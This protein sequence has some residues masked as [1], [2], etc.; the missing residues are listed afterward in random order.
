M[1]PEHSEHC[2]SCK[3][4]VRQ[5]LTA[6]YGHCEVNY[7]FTW[8][9]SPQHYKDTSVGDA[10]RRICDGLM[11]LRGHLD[12]VKSVQVPPCD[13]YILNPP[14]VLEFDE[15][16]HFSHARLVSLSLYPPGFKSGFPLSRWKELCRVIDAKDDEPPDRDERRAWY[17]T[18]RDLIPPL[19]S[20]NPTVRLYAN[21]FCWCSLDSA[22]TG[23]LEKFCS[24]LEERLPVRT[25]PLSPRPASLPPTPASIARRRSR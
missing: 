15:S 2:R 17:D 10:L 11:G 20:F 24:I 16:Q 21:E 22:S 13:F 7:S 4:R 12:F 8:P 23:D 5:L 3:E 1:I 14:F 19:H 18:L 6:V 9:A 25:P